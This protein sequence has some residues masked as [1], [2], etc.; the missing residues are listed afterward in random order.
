M[1]FLIVVVC[2][3]AKSICS[4][5]FCNLSMFLS[6]VTINIILL[7]LVA[8]CHLLLLGHMFKII[9]DS[10]SHVCACVLNQFNSY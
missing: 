5:R 1:T 7:K 10:L 3:L 6:F 9:M 4:K 2:L 8:K